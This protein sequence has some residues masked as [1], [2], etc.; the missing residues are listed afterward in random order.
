MSQIGTLGVVPSVPIRDTESTL[1]V[2]SQCPGGVLNRY[3]FST[4]W[5]SQVCAT[6]I[7]AFGT[8]SGHCGCPNQCPEP[9][10]PWVFLVVYWVWYT[11]KKPEWF[12]E[13]KP[14]IYL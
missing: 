7:A 2:H 12:F 8:L 5:V 3:T 10:T 4:L 6:E 14:K 11:K 9:S 13:E 1:Q